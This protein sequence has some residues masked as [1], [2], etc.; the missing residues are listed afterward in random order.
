MKEHHIGSDHIE[1]AF[2]PDNPPILMIEPGDVIVLILRDCFDGQFDALNTRPSDLDAARLNPLTGPVAINSAEPGDAIAVSV[3]DIKPKGTGIILAQTGLAT[4]RPHLAESTLH[5]V[6]V[7]D[8]HVELLPGIEIPQRPMIGTV[9]CTPN[10]ASVSSVF[11]G[12]HGGNMDH[13]LVAPGATVYLPISVPN[14][15][16]LVGDVHA[17]MGDGEVCTGVEISAEVRLKIEL[18]KSAL[19]RQPWIATSELWVSTGYSN[20]F[21]EA[22]KIAFQEM[23][24][25]VCRACQMTTEEGFIF[26]GTCGNLGISRGGSLFWKKPNGLT[27]QVTAR[28]ELPLEY[29]ERVCSDTKR[30][31]L[32]RFAGSVSEN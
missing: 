8:G 3:L 2:S 24:Q 22:L 11:A 16:L 27:P 6:R 17:L 9:G 4:M 18:V 31:S 14:G 13:A 28:V 12:S 7:T 21:I 26:V 1:Y 5:R 32:I 10:R 29:L 25:F 19:I 20:D 23:W 30:E 15:M